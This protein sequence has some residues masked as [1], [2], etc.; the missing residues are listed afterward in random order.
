MFPI[1]Q[2]TDS[3]DTTSEFHHP[4]DRRK[5]IG[6]LGV[7]GLGL[8]ASAAPAHAFSFGRKTAERPNVTVNT[9]QP[10]QA[11]VCNR[12]DLSGLPAEWA[13]QQ[14]PALKEYTRYISSLKL[15]NISTAQFISAHAKQKGSL[16]NTLPPKVWWSRMGYTLRV[17][18]RISQEMGQSE[19][20]IVSAYRSP[21]YNARCAGARRNS[22]HQANVAVDFEM[23]V[24][25]SQVTAAS[26]SLRDRG[27]FKGGIGGYSGFT[28][29][30]TRGQNINW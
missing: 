29:V 21:S 14:G 15:K 7:L 5:A 23:S 17:I 10:K 24:S 3:Q 30:D 6:S 19:V 4:L 9:K 2:Q 25:A 1:N 16:W 11:K 8:I 18:D 20:E 22:W 27:L 26:R 13:Y 28:H 12:I